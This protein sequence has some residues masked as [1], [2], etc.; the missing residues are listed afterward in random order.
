MIARRS[1]SRASIVDACAWRR[2]L[3]ADD[4]AAAIAQLA[5]DAGT[6][7]S[8]VALDHQALETDVDLD[9]VCDPVPIGP[10]EEDS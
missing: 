10:D 2:A 6:P 3:G 7:R 8:L 9:V 1:C 4:A 5:R